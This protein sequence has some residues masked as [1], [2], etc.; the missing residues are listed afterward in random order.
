M[1]KTINLRL[2]KLLLMYKPDKIVS[3]SPYLGKFPASFAALV[4]LLYAFRLT[5][6]DYNPSIYMFTIDPPTVKKHMGVKGTSS[7]K[8][9]MQQGLKK[10][11]I[12]YNEYRFLDLDEHAVDAMCVGL[13]FVS[14]F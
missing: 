13:T 11:K 5:V 2:A 6:F 10:K 9:L 3:E 7:D 8:T 4:E 1:I 12:N 14:L